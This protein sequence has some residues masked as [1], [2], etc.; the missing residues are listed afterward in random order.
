MII[1]Q[2]N[3]VFWKSHERECERE[4]LNHTRAEFNG[5]FKEKEK[6]RKKY[7]MCKQRRW[8]RLWHDI[9]I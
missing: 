1:S 5:F 3:F 8:S 7:E 4:N 2:E 6:E 9:L